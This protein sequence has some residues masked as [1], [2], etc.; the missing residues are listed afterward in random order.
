[1]KLI[2][3]GE[4]FLKHNVLSLLLSKT[5]RTESAFSEARPY[6]EAQQIITARRFY[7]FCVF[8]FSSAFIQVG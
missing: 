8:T 4:L 3:W 1:M 7:L 2:A 5:V 6:T